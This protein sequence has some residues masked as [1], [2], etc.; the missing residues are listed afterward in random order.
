MPMANLTGFIAD[1]ENLF[2][3]ELETLRKFMIEKSGPGA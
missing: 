3:A 2:D 1:I